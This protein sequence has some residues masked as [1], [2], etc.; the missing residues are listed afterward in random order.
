MSIVNIF[1][2]KYWKQIAVAIVI[3]I[4]TGGVSFLWSRLNIALSDNDRLNEVVY[5]KTIE[6]NDA[7]GR[8]VTASTEQRL[9]IGEL[10]RMVEGGDSVKAL[11]L[12]EI[13]NSNTKLKNV[14]SMAISVMKVHDTL[15]SQFFMSD[16]NAYDTLTRFSN[17]YFDCKRVSNNMMVCDY[18]DTLIWTVDSYKD[19]FKFKNL[20]VKRDSYYRLTA[21]YLNP[22]SKISYQEYIRI[23]S[24]KNKRNN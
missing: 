16:T 12:K 13:K 6:Y 17:D 7:E 2:K 22:S 21:K 23:D 4:L 15:Y 14:E 5:K 24:K 11:L 20:F 1:I 3:A 10:E 18:K 19:K 8:H 9:K